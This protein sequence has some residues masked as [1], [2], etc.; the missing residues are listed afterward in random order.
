MGQTRAVL[1]SGCSTG[2]GRAAAARFAEK[3]WPVYATARRPD[4]VADLAEVGAK[5]LQLDVTDESSMQQA[6]AAVEAEH[7]AVGVLVNNAGY[8]LE[9]PFELIPMEDVRRQ[10]ETNVFG[11][12]R[13]SQLVLP[14]MRAAR[15]GRIINISSMGGRLTFPGGAYY[16]G[17]KYAVEAMSDALR[18]E[19]KPFGVRVSVVEPGP[20]LAQFGDTAV[21]TVP[22]EDH[23]EYAPFVAGLKKRITEAY[24]GYMTRVAVG[25]EVIARVI[26][27]A[28]AADR[29]KA[30]YLIGAPARSLVTMRRLLPDRAWDA[31]MRLQFPPAK[32]R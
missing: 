29:P 10:F 21:G 18:Y 13:L 4:T 1:I 14:K 15:W 30:R 3:G 12:I 16:H 25:P 22:G 26:E 8:G 7:G 31:A 6:V 27:R 17:T 11:L 28:A 32:P 20:V 9:G 23:P 2:I 24:D 5:I 19:V